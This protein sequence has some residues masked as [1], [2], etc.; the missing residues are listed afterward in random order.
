MNVTAMLLRHATIATMD[1]AAPYGLLRDAA[2]LFEEVRH[3]TNFTSG[4]LMLERSLQRGRVR[5]V[6]DR[7]Q[8][9]GDAD[10]DHGVVHRRTHERAPGPGGEAERAAAATFAVEDPQRSRVRGCGRAIRGARA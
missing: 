6:G 8:A 9:R 3:L 1:G 10:R 4:P 5:R 2:Q 7:Q